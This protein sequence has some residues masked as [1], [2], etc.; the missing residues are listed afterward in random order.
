LM[1]FWIFILFNLQMKT[2]EDKTLGKVNRLKGEWGLEDK[3]SCF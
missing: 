1:F 3:E 2:R